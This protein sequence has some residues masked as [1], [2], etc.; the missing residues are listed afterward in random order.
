MPCESPVNMYDVSIVHSPLLH[1]LERFF[2]ADTQR[3]DIQVQNSSPVL[4][5]AG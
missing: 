1:G 3:Q 4:N 5:R 2:S